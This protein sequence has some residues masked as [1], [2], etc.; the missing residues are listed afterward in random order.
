LSFIEGPNAINESGYYDALLPYRETRRA[1]VLEDF[2]GDGRRM[3]EPNEQ[4]TT[5]YGTGDL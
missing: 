2:L 5:W 3:E 1:T 4:I